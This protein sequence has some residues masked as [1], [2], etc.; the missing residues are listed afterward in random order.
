MSEGG[1][2]K[3][4]LA[5]ALERGVLPSE[6]G[7]VLVEVAHDSWCPN[8]KDDSECTCDPEISARTW[9][10]VLVRIG[11]DGERLEDADACKPN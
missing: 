7:V 3:R 11:K 9:S 6:P 10:G 5:R 2:Y 1:E 8:L 4:R